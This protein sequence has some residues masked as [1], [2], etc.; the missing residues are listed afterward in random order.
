MVVDGVEDFGKDVVLFS[1]GSPFVFVQHLLPPYV[2]VTVFHW[3]GTTPAEDLY[4]PVAFLW[5]ENLFNLT[6]RGGV[7]SGLVSLEKH[8]ITP[9]FRDGTDHQ[10][11]SRNQKSCP[12]P[13]QDEQDTI[14]FR[15]AS[16]QQPTTWR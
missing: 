10:D 3:R 15:P 2:P 4:G 5:A 1:A 7:V 16:P 13:E 9:G 6:Y 8:R 12:P 11:R 14:C